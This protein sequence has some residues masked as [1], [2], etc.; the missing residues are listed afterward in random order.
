MN[1][2][3]SATGDPLATPRRNGNMSAADKRAL[4]DAV[5]KLGTLQVPVQRLAYVA[6]TDLL[7]GAAIAAATW[8]D[9]HA[10]QTF[11]VH[12][13]ASVLLVAANCSVKA[14]NGAVG[15]VELTLRAIVDSAGTPATVALDGDFLPTSGFGALGGG[16]FFA[17][18]LAAGS[19]TIKL[20]VYGNQ[21][22]TAYCRASTQANIEF[23][24]I[25]IYE[26]DP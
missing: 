17:T 21:A 1:F 22:W 11:A 18:G 24:N 26:L 8:T 12:S 19:H 23:V 15:A 16:T 7:S 13:A 2:Y 6:N 10:S 4:D 9:V 3:G 25:V 20:Q 14:V 5:A